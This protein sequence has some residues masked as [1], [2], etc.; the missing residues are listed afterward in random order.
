MSLPVPH[1]IKNWLICSYMYGYINMFFEPW[2]RMEDVN[3]DNLLF[4]RKKEISR[5]REEERGKPKDAN[6]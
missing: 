1:E 5:T 4:V 6:I 2:Q 3:D